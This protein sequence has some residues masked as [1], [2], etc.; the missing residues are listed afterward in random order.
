MRRLPLLALGTLASAAGLA[1]SLALASRSDEPT[2]PDF[3]FVA[4]EGQPA[5]R[6]SRRYD[7][8]PE[9]LR[10]AAELALW[11]SGSLLT[12]RLDSVTPREDGLEAT[13]RVGFFTDD[14]AFAVAP[15]PEG[16]SVLHVQSAARCGRSDLGVNAR[17]VRAF[18]AGIDTRLLR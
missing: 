8:A 10:T 15:L 11:H 4:P 14:F 12:G 17:R 3:P 9:A 1:A 5:V 6:L 13:F 16:G 2:A 18:L 7:A